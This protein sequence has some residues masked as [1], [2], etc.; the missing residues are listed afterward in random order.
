MACNRDIFTFF[1]HEC[2]WRSGCINYYFL[3]LGTSWRLVV[4]FTHLPL[5]PR[6]KNPHY[7]LDRRTY[8]FPRASL[9]EVEKRQFLTLVGLELR[10]IGR[11][12]RCKSLYRL[13]YPSSCAGGYTTLNTE[14]CNLTTYRNS[15]P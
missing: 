10:S 7:L 13:R 6:G 3:D 2:V 4:T 5:Y 11:P 12:A 1:P 8:M 14:V 15:D 9:D